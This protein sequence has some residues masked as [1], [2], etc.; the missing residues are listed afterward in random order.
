MFCKRWLA[1]VTICFAFLSPSFADSGL[2]DSIYRQGLYHYSTGN[3]AG[4]VDYLEQV[5]EMAPAN[6][7]ARFYLAYCYSATGKV[8]KALLLA[9]LLVSRYPHDYQFNILLQQLNQQKSQMVA[10]RSSPAHE[11]VTPSSSSSIGE[12]RSPREGGRMP[13]KKTVVRP[14]TVLDSAV[15]MI[16]EEKFASASVILNGLLAKEPKNDAVLHYLGILHFNQGNT[17][18][19]V[20]NFEKAVVAGSK[21]FETRFFLATCYLRQQKFAQA[22]K[23]FAK[24]LEI[25]DD[26]FC[27]LNLA[28]I[29]SRNYRLDEAEKMLK[30]IVKVS[31]DVIDARVG[32]VQIELDRGNLDLAMTQIN[33]ILSANTD[34]A[35]ARLVKARI[36]ME[37]KHYAD[38][39]DEALAAYQSNPLNPEF[40]ACYALAL[41]RNFSVIDAMKEIDSI[42]DEYPESTD[43]IMA[44]AEGLIVSGR[45]EEA[46]KLLLDSEKQNK[47]PQASFLLARVA[48][49]ESDQQQARKY[50]DEFRRRSGNRPA[51][52]I[53]YARFIES[54]QA[55]AD[56]IK[57]YKDVLQ[58]HPDSQ[59]AT[60]ATTALERL[61]SSAASPSRPPEKGKIPIPGFGNP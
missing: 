44:M 55:D 27:K 3:F 36:L 2:I 25:K 60:E 18:A 8:D 38:A 42:L 28:E 10:V 33:E 58:G 9:K 34:S 21:R 45:L 7:Q 1:V 51:A 54:I 14:V 12:V 29:Y 52:M 17:V 6:D 43:A 20:E 47:L 13:R 23:H 50:Y 5:I 56:A 41:I 57:A 39:A 61:T 48:M 4:A 11:S 46:K 32:L 59:Y 30:S 16:D 15:E 53:E 35:R 40:R 19:A 31:P 26:V 24:A 22:E 49:G 37:H